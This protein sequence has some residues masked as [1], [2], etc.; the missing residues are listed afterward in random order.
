MAY[1]QKNIVVCLDGTGNQ[2]EENLSNVLKLYRTVDKTATQVVFYDQGVGTL[3]QVYTWGW[4]RQKIRNGLGLA[5]GRGL[6]ENVLQAYQFIVRH[7]EE[8]TVKGQKLRDQIYIFGFSRGAHTARVLAGMLYEVGLLRPNQIHLSGAALTAYKQSV[9][10]DAA[11]ND[12]DYE[13]EGANFR[14]VAAT[15]TASVTFMGLW[16]TVSSVFIPNPRGFLP[17]LRREKLPHTTINP[18]VRACRHALAVDERRRMFRPD[19]WPSKQVFKPNSHSQ[20]PDIA[21][22]VE[23]RWFAGCHADVGGGYER[24]ASALSQIPLQWMLTQAKA[25]GLKVSSRMEKYVTGVKPWTP[26][27]TYLYPE[28]DAMGVIHNSLLPYWWLIEWLPKLAILREWQQRW[29]LLWLIYIPWAEPRYIQ[30]N[31]KIAPSVRERM[32]EREDYRPI[33]VPPEKH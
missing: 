12:S 13:G 29:R 31:A 17:P 11:A 1:K 19:H 20:G 33:N 24:D 25:A 5:F 14:R 23:E 22:D 32:K 30:P 18:A 8:G 9:P 21:Q 2:I 6:D 4:L 16:D 28:P 15:R 27:T 10:G 7:Y 26:K 3:G